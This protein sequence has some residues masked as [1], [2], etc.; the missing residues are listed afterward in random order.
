MQAW[1]AV[2]VHPNFVLLGAVLAILSSLQ[3]NKPAE[4]F[5]P[6]QQNGDIFLTLYF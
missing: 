1:L 6:W 4:K 2:V 3:D 5:A